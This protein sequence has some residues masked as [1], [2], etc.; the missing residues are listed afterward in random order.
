MSFSELREHARN[1]L[2]EPKLWRAIAAGGGPAEQGVTSSGVVAAANWAA[3]AWDFRAGSERWQARTHQFSSSEVEALVDAASATGLLRSALPTRNQYD[4][5]VVLGGS[6]TANRVRSQLA[7][8][9]AV[10][11]LLLKHVVGLGSQRR[12]SAEECSALPTGERDLD[13]SAN[14][15]RVLADAADALGVEPSVVTVPQTSRGR[16]PDTRESI[17]HLCKVLDPPSNS[18]MLFITNA[19]YAPYQY[20]TGAGIALEYGACWVEVVGAP[21]PTADPSRMARGIA[22]E[23][24]ATLQAA[25]QLA[26]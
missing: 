19:L 17:E 3:V 26:A 10:N 11:G 12:I 21:T 22:Q 2:E 24:N 4:I 5:A 20:F 14:L 16:R 7:A 15:A 8:D 1:W 18:S 23:L 9:L 13:E 25:G 6:V